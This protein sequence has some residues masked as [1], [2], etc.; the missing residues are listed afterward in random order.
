MFSEWCGLVNFSIVL[1]D[2]YHFVLGMEF[3]HQ[4]KAI[5]VPINDTMCI[6]GG[7]NT[8]MVPLSR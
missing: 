2:D 6:I 1:V 8:C 5:L 3:V 4:V 7:E